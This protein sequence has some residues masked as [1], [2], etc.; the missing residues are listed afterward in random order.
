VIEERS[1]ASRNERIE[2]IPA[3]KLLAGARKNKSSSREGTKSA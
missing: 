2:R 3:H 1:C